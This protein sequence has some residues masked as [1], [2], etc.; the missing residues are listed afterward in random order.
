MGYN[1]I[2]HLTLNKIAFEVMVTGEK[3]EEFR[4]NSDWIRTRLFDRTGKEKRY[5]YIKFVNGYGKDKPYFICE[6]VDFLEAYMPISE[7]RYSNGLVVSGLGKG[8]F[9]IYCGDIVEKGNLKK[10]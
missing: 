7:R 6:Y 4:K 3:V 1:K 10:V 9:I 5:D 8:D 2:L